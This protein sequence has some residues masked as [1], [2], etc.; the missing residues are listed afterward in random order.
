MQ[1][2]N[3]LVQ[4]AYK[5]KDKQEIDLDHKRYELNTFITKLNHN[6]IFSKN[7]LRQFF[8]VNFDEKHSYTDYNS[9]YSFLQDHSRS[10]TG[11]PHFVFYYYIEQILV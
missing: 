3:R 11:D 8:F 9:Q 1:Q 4:V 5:K 2:D 10:T 7:F 6:S